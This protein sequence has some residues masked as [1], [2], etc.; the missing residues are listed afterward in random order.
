MKLS[1]HASRLE[2]WLGAEA[3]DRLVSS[4]KDWYGPPIAVAGVPGN[5]W[6]V[7]GGDFVGRIEAGQ[8]TNALDFGVARVS[9][10]LRNTARRQMTQ[11]TAGFTS[12]SDLIAE[13]TAGK[14]REIVMQKVGATGVIAVTNSLWRLGNQPAAGAAGA[15]APGGTAHTGANTGAVYGLD[16]VSTDT[17]HIVSAWA[18]ASVAGQTLLLYDRLFSVAIGLTGIS[19]AMSV[20]GVPTRYQ[21]F[22]ATDPDYVGGNFAFIEVGGTALAATAHNWTVCR[23]RNQANTDQVSFPSMTGNSGAIADRLDHPVSSWFFP[24]ASGDTGVAD[25]DQIQASA[26]MATGAANAVVGH[27]LAFMPIPLANI[28]CQYD[29]INTAFN[30]VRVFDGACLAWLEISKPSTSATT[31][32]AGVTMIHG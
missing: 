8:F 1:T 25:L 21:S 24:L 32:N 27:P 10:I 5:V 26:N 9:R 30:L 22:T 29:G 4:V 11:A 12:L 7:K 19:T 31:Y 17:R 2:R 13:A 15:A 6:A 14:R 20:T 18:V 23:Y 28:A 3:L 16:D